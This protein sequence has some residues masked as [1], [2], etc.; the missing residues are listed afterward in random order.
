MKPVLGGAVFGEDDQAPVAPDS[1]RVQL[2]LQP[3]D[4]R[5]TLASPPPAELIGGG[6]EVIQGGQVIAADVA[7]EFSGR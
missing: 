4:E 6:N 2:G 3:V 7:E 1:A 5:A